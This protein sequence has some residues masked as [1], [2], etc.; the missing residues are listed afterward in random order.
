MPRARKKRSYRGTVLRGFVFGHYDSRGGTFF[1]EARDLRAAKRRLVE[2]FLPFHCRGATRAEMAAAVEQEVDDDVMS[3]AQLFIPRD[4][5][6]AAERRFVDLDEQG[7]VL[8]PVNPDDPRDASDRSDFSAWCGAARTV[9]LEFVLR[10]TQ[11]QMLKRDA[12]WPRWGDDAYG[13]VVL[14]R[15]RG[16]A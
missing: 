2:A 11:P 16:G 6:D 14:R 9:R 3:R 12:R 4:I 15:R 8:E 1:V 5:A 7:R 10:G 13:F